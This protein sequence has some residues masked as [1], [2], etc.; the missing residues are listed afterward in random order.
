M[1]VSIIILGDNFSSGKLDKF[2]NKNEIIM[3]IL[4]VF[5]KT[6]QLI[7]SEIKSNTKLVLTW[8]KPN[9]QFLF[10]RMA[11]FFCEIST[12]PDGKILNWYNKTNIH[13]VLY[14]KLQVIAQFTFVSVVVNRRPFSNSTAPCHVIICIC[15]VA[16]DFQYPCQS[17]RLCFYCKW[18]VSQTDYAKIKHLQRSFSYNKYQLSCV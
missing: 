13:D 10:L 9:G 17:W 8:I 16:F 12:F 3:I 15:N 6:L 7:T 11:L 2:A 1:P 4:L 5:C 18:K 14:H